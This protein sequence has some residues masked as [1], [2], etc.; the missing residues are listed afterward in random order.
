MRSRGKVHYNIK[1]QFKISL[2]LYVYLS[3]GGRMSIPK[4]QLMSALRNPK[5]P[6]LRRLHQL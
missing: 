5:P 2:S 4:Q 3:K 1:M 6:R